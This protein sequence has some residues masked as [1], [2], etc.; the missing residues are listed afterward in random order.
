[1]FEGRL[2]GK[3]ESF[4]KERQASRQM[5]IND[6]DHLRGL[7]DKYIDHKMQQLT[8]KK[9]TAFKK[10]STD[11]KRLQFAQKMSKILGQ[12]TKRPQFKVVMRSERELGMSLLGN[13]VENKAFYGGNEKN[14]V[15]EEDHQIV[16]GELL[17]NKTDLIQDSL[18]NASKQD[19]LKF[20]PVKAFGQEIDGMREINDEEKGSKGFN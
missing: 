11:D 10:N 5:T 14:I 16:N 17:G 15:N 3:A 2:A 12:I 9:L 20:K 6:Y 8:D 19:E 7:C 18:G 4:P 1:K 13:I